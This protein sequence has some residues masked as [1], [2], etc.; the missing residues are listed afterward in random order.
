[1]IS[2]RSFYTWNGKINSSALF[3]I[4]EVL[5]Q[6]TVNSPILFNIFISHIINACKLNQN[7]N[8]YS[9]AYAD[10]L[11]I[12]VAEKYPTKLKNILE[13][14]VNKINNL[15]A[16]WNL[17]VSPEK[18][19]TIVFRKPARFVTKAKRV[20]N[21]KFVIETFKPDT[22]ELTKIP[23]KSVVKYLGM[24]IDYLAKCNDHLDQQLIKARNSFRSLNRLFHNRHISPR[25]K[26][27]CYQLLIRPLL[28]YAA[29][30]CWNLG[31]AQME[32][33]RRFERACLRTAL[34]MHRRPETDYQHRICNK[35]IFD[36]PNIPRIDNHQLKLTRDY[37]SKTK[38][39][40]NNII[41]NL[42]VTTG[43]THIKAQKGLLQPQDFTVL[44]KLGF[45]QD[46]Y[47]IPILYHKS[48]HKGDK[49]INLTTFKDSPSKY[50]IALPKRDQ[51]DLHRLDAEKY[52][53]TCKETNE[54]KD[55]QRRKL[56]INN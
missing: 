20:N 9:I 52:W 35:E 5:Q 25:A 18:C 10:D 8:T 51:I 17:R 26:V 22:R 42:R 44:D 15:F 34:S 38:D 32:K 41:K 37:F 30:V 31:A 24:N 19:M 6:G 13:T 53:W 43:D 33:V 2:E 29:P 49:S 4:Q 54:Y 21:E 11:I 36:A 12:Y 46:G 3:K 50:S 45:I 1:M 40:N 7:N 27:I 14:L 23:T 47:N 16:R 56:L 55:L 48:R 39:I 28:T